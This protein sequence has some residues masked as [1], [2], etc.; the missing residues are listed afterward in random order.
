MIREP[1]EMEIRV[2]DAMRRRF[3]IGFEVIPQTPLQAM[4]FYTLL[5]QD[6]L[7]AMREP[8]EEIIEAGAAA[9]PDDRMYI[10][11]WQ[12]MIDAASPPCE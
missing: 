7:R 3:P 4:A 6:A 9:H 10:R 8:T 1:T 2:A 5:A 12:A 11:C